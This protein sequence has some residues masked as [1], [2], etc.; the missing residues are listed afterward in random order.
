MPRS[1]SKIPR[2]PQEAEDKLD[3]LPDDF[4]EDWGGST[5][6]ELGEPP[7]MPGLTRA[8]PVPPPQA[9]LDLGPP[10]EDA[11]EAA[12]W[13]YRLLMM[14]AY[15][16]LKRPMDDAE[17]DRVVRTILRD[18]SKHMTDAARYDYKMLVARQ[19]RELDNRRRGAPRGKMEAA[20]PPPAA[21]KVG[22][23]IPIRPV[24]GKAV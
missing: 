9:L 20:P 22:V 1:R 6:D 15:E 17:R 10:P 8:A 14:Q 19:E 5:E 23:V 24:D 4:E 7:P 18:A 12:K 21:A 13:A 3:D 11:L 2:L 16:T